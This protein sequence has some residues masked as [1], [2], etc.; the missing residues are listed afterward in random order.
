MYPCCSGWSTW[1]LPAAGKMCMMYRAPA[2]SLLP[3]EGAP[4]IAVPEGDGFTC[5][6]CWTS[7][8]DVR[9]RIPPAFCPSVSP[10]M[11]APKTRTLLDGP[12]EG[13]CIAEYRSPRIASESITW[14]AYPGWL[15]GQWCCPNVAEFVT[16]A[17]PVRW[18]TPST[19]KSSPVVNSVR[20][21]GCL[22]D[23][24]CLPPVWAGL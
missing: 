1:Q 20:Q 5:I 2:R 9:S 22:S 18:P 8:S 17:Q 3:K 11:R 21:S 4:C 12:D 7:G 14:P 24:E 6:R 10:R 19:A 16:R 23:G 13:T 15:P